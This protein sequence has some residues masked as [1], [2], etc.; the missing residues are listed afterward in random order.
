VY[1]DFDRKHI[2]TFSAIYNKGDIGDESDYIDEFK[3]FLKN[4]YYTHPD[5]KSL[6]EDIPNFVRI[7]AEPIPALGPYAQYKVMEKA[8]GNVV[9]TLDGQGADEELAGYHYFFGFFFKDL[10]TSFR[11]GQLVKEMVLYYKYHHSAFA[12]KTFAYFLLPKKMRT[13]L[14]VTKYNYLDAP[15]VKQY[16]NSN[17]IAG[18]LYGSSSLNDSLL[19]H[20]NYKLEHLL[21]WDDRNSMASSIESRV[22]FLDYRLVE[23]TLASANTEKIHNGVTKS[24]LREA[25]KGTL[26]EKVRNRMDKVGFDTPQDEWF[27]TKLF[28]EFIWEIFNSESFSKRSFFDVERVREL[29]KRHINREVSVAKEIWKCVNLELWFRE[30]IDQKVSL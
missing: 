21:K 29:Y 22:P 19:D 15:F 10:F 5:E 24:I 8:K 9:V 11:W 14:R 26:P 1:N 23:R 25:M 3:P 2:N 20:F 4:M 16:S 28:Q 6:M 17:T 7:H 27:R 18:N 30:F 12:Y 13:S